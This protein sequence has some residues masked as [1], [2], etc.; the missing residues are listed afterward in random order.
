MSLEDGEWCECDYCSNQGE[1][2]CVYYDL[3]KKVGMVKMPA[4]CEECPVEDRQGCTSCHDPSTTVYGKD[5]CYV[6]LCKF[7]LNL[8]QEG[9]NA[10]KS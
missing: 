4:S 2:E 9:N 5:W 3:F 1:P 6:T 8:F 10:E 7:F